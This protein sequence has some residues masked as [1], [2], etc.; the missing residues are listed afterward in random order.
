MDFR[1]SLEKKSFSRAVYI[2]EGFEKFKKT[3]FIKYRKR[4]RDRN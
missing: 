1:G 2:E 4:F 3:V